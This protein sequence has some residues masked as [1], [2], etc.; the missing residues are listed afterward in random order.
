LIHPF[1]S[2]GVRCSVTP[3]GGYRHPAAFKINHRI[4]INLMAT[5]F[6]IDLTHKLSSRIATVSIDD[7]TA[8]PPSIAK[9]LSR[10][11]T[12]ERWQA[13]LAATDHP[14]AATRRFLIIQKRIRNPIS[15]ATLYAWARAFKRR[16]LEGLIDGRATVRG[17]RFRNADAAMQHTCRRLLNELVDLLN[18]QGL[19][20]VTLF[21]S[22]LAKRRGM[23]KRNEKRPIKRTI[24]PASKPV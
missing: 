16:G 24:E 12:L 6:K 23:K 21:A 17:K 10:K 5:K 3:L 8:I 1:L 19:A 15:R 2:A 11:R 14:E 9:S 20:F 22:M 7:P 4:G 13:M 18:P